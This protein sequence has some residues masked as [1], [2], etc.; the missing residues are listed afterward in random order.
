MNSLLTYDHPYTGTTS[1]LIE[2]PGLPV[3]I[4][5]VEHRG[6]RV[7]AELVPMGVN[8]IQLG[9]DG[10]H[11]TGVKVRAVNEG[12][13]FRQVMTQVLPGAVFSQT[14]SASGGTSIQCGGTVRMESGREPGAVITVPSGSYLNL[15]KHGEIIVEHNGTPMTL[16]E[17]A[18]L[19]LL[20]VD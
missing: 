5:V 11:G 14:A 6:A 16:A 9:P 20:E 7:S 2:V 10:K 13:N 17:A 19:G 18:G 4:K 3:T 8:A 12:Q 15:V 1:I